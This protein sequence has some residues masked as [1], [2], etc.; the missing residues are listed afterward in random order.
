[1]KPKT[2]KKQL[3]RE[4]AK[5]L[6]IIKKHGSKPTSEMKRLPSQRRLFYASVAMSSSNLER[7]LFLKQWR[8]CHAGKTSW[9]ISPTA[10]FILPESSTHWLL[11]IGDE[12]RLV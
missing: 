7:R 2:K 12:G 1:M 6:S 4:A 3:A 9:S 8:F 10:L 11:W 5:D